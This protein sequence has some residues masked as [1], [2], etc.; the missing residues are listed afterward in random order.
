MT[1]KPIILSVAAFGAINFSF[2][3]LAQSPAAGQVSSTAQPS[4]LPPNSNDPV[5]NELE[6]LRKSLQTQNARLKDVSEKY[7]GPDA[8][9]NNPANS[10]QNRIATNLEILS[11]AE[12]RAEALRRL[13]LDLTEKETAYKSRLLQIDEDSRP[14]NIERSMIG[15]GTTRSPELRET[16]SRVLENDKRGYQTLLSQTAQSRLRLDEDVRQADALVSRLR[17]RVLPQI[18]KEIDKIGPN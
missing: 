10:P 12:Q 17:Q 15:F 3:T 1:I 14:E 2:P 11:R 18:D 4:N 8:K 7:L 6:L 13:L 5:A 9:S 16:R